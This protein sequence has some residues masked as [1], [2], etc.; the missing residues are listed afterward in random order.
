MG[1]D[2]VID[3]EADHVNSQQ[4]AKTAARVYRDGAMVAENKYAVGYC[5][6]GTAQPATYRV[7][8][9]MPEG[10][11]GWTVGTESSS[12]WTFTS[13]RPTAPGW[14]SVDA[15]TAVWDLALD[16]NN[17]APAG[18]SF[19]VKLNVGHQPGAQA[20]PIKTTKASVSFDDGGTWKK[21]PVFVAADGSYVGSVKHPKLRDT[22]GFV[23]LKF[24]V[25]DTAGNKFEQTLYRAYAL[26]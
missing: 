9:D 16:L 4:G 13:G 3:A 2:S 24:E 23:S 17:S 20:V 7:E 1:F 8:L 12:A 22:S 18:K 14:Q 19:P 11:P 26:R 25:T 21:I 5:D 15:V 6:V 10:R